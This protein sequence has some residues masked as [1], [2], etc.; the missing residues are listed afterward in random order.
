MLLAVQFLSFTSLVK[1]LDG[2]TTIPNKVR[3]GG[4][5]NLFTV[6][7]IS[8]KVTAPALG[9]TLHL[10]AGIVFVMSVRRC[11]VGLNNAIEGALDTPASPRNS[12]SLQFAHVP[13]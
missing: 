3:Q 5:C 12:L 9:P 10:D 11:C 8:H 7:A 6:N 1:K 13:C 2:D 4:A